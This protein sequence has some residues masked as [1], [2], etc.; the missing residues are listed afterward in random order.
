MSKKTTKKTT[1][2][3]VAKAPQTY[4]VVKTANV[5]AMSKAYNSGYRRVGTY[6]GG[7]IA[8]LKN[9]TVQT[10]TN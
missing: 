9:D 1:K 4:M 6:A 2:T 7:S 5:T 8:V 10:P 3:K